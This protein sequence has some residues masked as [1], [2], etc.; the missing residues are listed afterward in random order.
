MPC[1]YY[2][3]NCGRKLSQDTVLF[4]MQYILTKQESNKFSIL[5]FRLT[6]P[7]LTALYNA[8]TPLEDNFRTCQLTLS[9][10]MA[11]ISDGNNLNDSAVAGLTMADIDAYLKEDSLS[12][13]MGRM[14]NPQRSSRSNRKT[15]QIRTK[16]GRRP[17]CKRT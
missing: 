3:T 2:C 9:E 8:G 12:S 5:K 11:F 14:E 6:L 17:C 4:D 16:Y 15:L 13:A 10:L 1:E 7:A